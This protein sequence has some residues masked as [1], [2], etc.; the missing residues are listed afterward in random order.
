[1]I[2]IDTS[3]PFGARIANQL[4]NDEIMWL[5]TVDANGTPQ[6]VPVWFLWD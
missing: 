2:S 1:M 4:A 6:P 3:T 5:T